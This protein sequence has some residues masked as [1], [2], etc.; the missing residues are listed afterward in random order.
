MMA[1][2]SRSLR[3]LTRGL[4]LALTL[5]LLALAHPPILAQAGC[6]SAKSPD[7]A[8]VPRW[9]EGCGRVDPRG[10]PEQ[11]AR[12]A[13]AANASALGLR[14]ADADLAL[15]SVGK[16]AGATHVRFA[17]RYKG[18]PVYLGEVLVQ[19]GPDGAIQ[20]I[21]NQMAP[22]LSLD[23]SPAVG[24][25]AALAAAQAKVP[26]SDEL[27]APAA[28]ELVVYP[29]DGR[30]E[31]AYHVVLYTRRPAGDWHVMVSARSGAVLAAWD[32]IW[33]DSGSG[34]AYAPNPVQQSGTT[35]L[36]DNNDAAGPAL[37]AARAPVTLQHLDA[38][39][40][41]L[42]GRSVDTT[43]PGVLGCELPYVGGQADEVSRSYNYTRDDDRFEEV[44]VYAAID[45][46]QSW[47]QALGFTNVNNRSIPVN[48]HCMAADNSYYS[49]GD[50]ALHFGDGGV[51]DA[52]DA[53]IVVHEYGHSVQA[54][55][56]PGWGP[57][58]N[59]EQR[60][61]G[62]G[63]GDFLAGIY[64]VNEGNA[65][66]LNAR[67][68][69]IGD[70]DAVSYNPV[71]P[72][73]PG[74]GCLRWING[75]N[76]RNGADIGAYRGTPSE[77][78]D[79]G[80]YWSAALTCM[81]EGMGGDVSARDAIMKLVLQHHFSLLPDSGNQAFDNAVD[82]L[83]LADASLFGGAH[84]QLILSCAVARNLIQQPAL[85]VPAI[86]SPA[87]GATVNAGAPV[88][89][90]WNS[91]GAPASAAFQLQY[92]ECSIAP[93]FSDDV[94]SGDGGWV[95][96]HENGPEDWYQ[97][98][99]LSHSPTHSWFASDEAWLNEQYMVS[100]PIQL[101]GNQELRF[102]HQYNME[103]GYDGGALEISADGGSSWSDL[104]PHI[105]R[106]GYSGRIYS[107]V[108]GVLNDRPV[109][110][111]D[112]GGWME[113]QVDLSRFAGRTIRLRFVQADDTSVSVTGWYVDDI[114]VAPTLAWTTVA[115]SGAGASSYNWTAPDTPGQYCLRVRAEA[116]GYTASGYSPVR[117]FTVAGPNTPPTLTPFAD[118]TV[119]VG[120]APAPIG[121]S[122]GDT[123]TPAGELVVVGSSSNQGLLPD[124]GITFGGSGPART[125]TLSPRA[126]A[127]GVATVTI[128]VSDGR[129]TASESFTFTVR[130]RTLFLPLLDR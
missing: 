56:V 127:Y 25:P 108:G 67:K 5:P 75:R 61:M 111:G 55:Q 38:A 28:H 91:A 47:F 60:A 88:T 73:N 17:Q 52:E 24:A 48:V 16:S 93:A 123:E 31:L 12:R 90:S 37:D 64:Y 57:G 50:R 87:E 44:T 33:G 82:A 58:R 119:D 66:Y 40:N 78:H 113:T 21:N 112:S 97:V 104:G 118:R 121:F 49:D 3:F 110:T 19:Y 29:G 51:D 45:G 71:S 77:E 120:G 41:R 96:S 62:E 53:D 100:P 115:T 107:N 18:L 2:S 80:R 46:V 122:V 30:P 89:V 4:V 70:W 14:S 84:Q 15:E 105:V 76:E 1:R 86:T 116:P 109:F 95:L 130:P 117:H 20:L 68:Y 26:G 22:G 7:P 65:A 103:G 11:I 63:F 106:G 83:R 126:G 79:D 39:T 81:Y 42:K 36:A 69:C 128:S 27:R 34:R 72:A 74:S 10:T 6:A 124:S 98:A 129:A 102:W 114:R 99:Y 54:N 85:P 101:E 43:G 32:A 13:L 8:G 92:A 94:E 59:T 35:T 23:V 125:L 9:L